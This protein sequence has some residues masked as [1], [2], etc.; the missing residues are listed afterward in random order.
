MKFEPKKIEF[1]SLENGNFEILLEVSGDGDQGMR[2]VKAKASEL[3]GLDFIQVVGLFR[4]RI[5]DAFGVT[6]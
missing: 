5:N 6:Q 4:A 3:Q 1:Q 2:T